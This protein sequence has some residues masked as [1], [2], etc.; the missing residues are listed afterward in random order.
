MAAGK[1]TGGRVKGVPNKVTLAKEAELAKGGTM[2]LDHM[3]AVLRNPKT[4]GRRKDWAANAAAPYCHPK[5]AQTD[6]NVKGNVTV[7]LLPSDSGLV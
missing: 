3:L 7:S 4:A 2:P 5:L 6:L 1:K